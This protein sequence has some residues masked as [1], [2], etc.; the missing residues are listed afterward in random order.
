MSPFDSMVNSEKASEAKRILL[1]KYLDRQ[2]KGPANGGGAITPRSGTGPVPLSFAQQQVWLH[3]QIAPTLPIYN[4]P[5]TVH[6]HGPLDVRSFERALTEIIRRHEAWRTTF[7]VLEAQ[8][9]QV[10]QPPF[11]VTLPVVD[12]RE[13]SPAQREA[14]ALRLA[15]ADAQVPFDLTQ[16]PLLRM[17]LIRLEE[18]EYRLYMTLHQIILDG[19][20]AYQ[21]FLPELITLYDAFC[22]GK[23]SP[24]PELPI[25]AG[26]YACWQREGL[27]TGK[28]AEH[29]TYW[30]KQLG[31]EL[32]V[33]NLPT[34]RP[35]PAAQTFRGEMY[36]LNIAPA[37]VKR[38]RDMSQH[39][40]VTM[41]MAMLAAFCVVLKR[42]TAQDEVILG[43]VTACRP[44]PEVEKL[45][46]Y[47]VNPV[48]LRINVSG[49]PS[50]RELL[51]RVRD[52]VLGAIS[53]DE[54]PFEYLVRELQPH[55]DLSRNPLFQIMISLEPPMPAI[56]GWSMTQF[57]VASGASKFDL[58]LDMDDRD[59]GII[60]PVT[61]N[62]DLFDRETIARLVRHWEMVLAA[63]A[64]DPACQVGTLPILAPSEREELLIR[65]NA[66]EKEEPAYTVPE[67]FEDQVDRTPQSL[68]VEDEHA[69]WTYREINNRA[70]QIARH[71]QGVG[72]KAQDVV[73][74]CTDRRAEMVI[75]LLAVLKAGA[76]Y[77][78]VDPSYPRERVAFMLRDSGARVILTQR[79]QA[80]KLLPSD[81]Q[82]VLLDDAPTPGGQ[83]DCGNLKRLVN[84]EDLAYVI[85]TS[86]STGTPKG[87]EITHRSLVNLLLAMRQKPG[88]EAQDVLLAVT[89]FSFDIAGLELL[90]PLIRGARVVLATT[91]QSENGTEL[92][93]RLSSCRATV[94]Q[95]TP[96]TWRMLIDAG[97]KGDPDLKVLCG[98][99]A[100]SREL[101]DGLLARSSSVWNMYGPTETTI[102][103]AVRRVTPGVEAVDIGEP[104]A[105]TQMH[106]L[107]SLGQLLPPGV[108]GELHI[109]GHGLARGYRNQ[110]ELTRQK[111]IANPFSTQTDARLYKT[112]DCVR[113]T[114]GGRLEFLGRLDNQV[115]LHGYRIELGEIESAL[116]L[117]SAVKSV[118]VDVRNGSS[119]EKQLIA[120]IV[121]H[122]KAP[123][124]E[125]LRS[126]LR[127]K[128]PG[129]M[130]PAQ[131]VF[132][133]SLPLMA[134]GKLNRAALP[135]P[136]Q[137]SRPEPKFVAP[138]SQT[139]K[140][141]CEI[142]EAVL[143][144]NSIGIG[145]NFFDLGGH[146]LLV[147]RLVV[148]LEQVFHRKLSLADIFQA[149][150]I[151]QMAKLLSREG[152]PVPS[153]VVAI[154]PHGQNPPLYWI[155][156]GPL[157]LPLTRRLGANQPVFGLHLTSQ[158]A[159]TLPI[160][161]TVEHVA[162]AFVRKLRK[163]QP[164]GPY[165]LG[166]L[167]IDGVLAYEMACQL[168][169]QN[170]KIALLALVD[171]HNPVFYTDFS[172]DGR[173]NITYRRLAFHARK[174]ANLKRKDIGRYVRDRLDGVQRR[175]DALRWQFAYRS[176]R[177]KSHAGIEELDYI[178]HPAANSYHPRPYPGAVCF[179]QS[180]DWPAGQYWDFQR[181][182][183]DLV[184]G[185]FNVYRI[186][187][188]HKTTFQ[189]DK[190][191]TLGAGLRQCLER[192]H[193][194]PAAK[195]DAPAVV[196]SGVSG[197]ATSATNRQASA[198][199]RTATFDDYEGVAALH[200][201]YFPE[202]KS[203]TEW[204]RLWS[205]NPVYQQ[206]PNWPIGWVLQ[207]HD[208]RIVGYLG[209]VPLTMEFG[210]EHL[211][212]TTCYALVVDV[213]Y[214]NYSLPLLSSFFGQKNVALFIDTTVNANAC[215]AHEIF[216][217]RRVP[218]GK[219]DQSVF[220][221]TNPQGFLS[222]WLRNKGLPFSRTLSYPL[223]AG[224]HIH[225][226]ASQAKLKMQLNGLHFQVHHSFD[227]RFEDFWQRL[228]CSH[229]HLLLSTRSREVLEWHFNYSLTD[230]RAWVATL[231]NASG[232]V[233][234]AI[235][236]RQD[237]PTYQLKRMR[238]VDFQ[239]VNG[240]NSLLAPLAAWGLEQCRANGIHMLETIGLSPEKQR[241]LDQ[242]EPY[243][244]VLPSWLYFYKATNPKL[245]AKLE[246][247][248]VWD[249]T[250]FDGDASL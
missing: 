88:L 80:G 232:I 223:A 164:H 114:A 4:E 53:H 78:P 153:G 126:F 5:F 92:L 159:A 240:D 99:E 30:H 135:R 65:F 10:V 186:P 248:A 43:T 158:E 202:T 61:Y 175:I 85:Y 193:Q 177:H 242:L 147:T 229:S 187:G 26:D 41:F 108:P 68:A 45:L 33:L 107:D 40:G 54:V 110:P 98:G 184:G 90:L 36:P 198:T 111:F 14:E 244:R 100:L 214:R 226:M 24:L 64:A 228:R 60:G 222:S 190:V 63:A 231:S 139:E 113:R 49:N 234:Y 71:L 204:R 77:V 192:A 250:W 160:R 211:L 109:G 128:L 93:Q 140:Q 131:F 197:D 17:K 148:R 20:T 82:L 21:V 112:G 37:L 66:T 167:C 150:T 195:T 134:N 152:D 72:V 44:R 23:P 178:V 125:E 15:T 97:W 32:P 31:G 105:N 57:D 179:F 168:R 207:N 163:L 199:V 173:W 127:A 145:Q 79:A 209:N 213:Q 48:V 7:S 70:N 138:R 174:L 149:P 55:R 189:E 215:K 122:S 196:R 237:N 96:A 34:D 29:M 235:F 157:L 9:V 180:T 11:E 38:V 25:Q 249:P 212:T 181:G 171:A 95:G 106:V 208:R 151:E 42:Y 225:Q 143:D 243:K 120:Y 101:A 12:L 47:F 170:E 183:R 156:G 86:G 133:E 220:W 155:R 76:A 238:L 3:S 124:T 246:D 22:A 203:Y 2:P 201:Q 56:E 117:H 172:Q 247:P 239:T 18:N 51:M 121:A 194:N 35:R 137:V 91:A 83:Q 141:L 119:A 103:S 13:L 74:I 206:L 8:P 146:S 166:G 176:W 19:V 227:D 191:E 6:R 123:A 69:R 132:L 130:L 75:S 233:A 200:S 136:E 219:W 236:H 115:K 230:N 1:E 73:A 129:Y 224:L 162:E 118:A 161:C 218:T 142:W 39:E 210:G 205:D 116:S 50:F 81:A 28:L 245:A 102:W 185:K 188:G 46:G 216:R 59:Q 62:P 84:A 89:T 104:I 154:Q 169:Q 217:A 87:V 241:I 94:M 182:W 144:V 52:V 16:G 58:Y 67:L 165:Y 27:K 221:I